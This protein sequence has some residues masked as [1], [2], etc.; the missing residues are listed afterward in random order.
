MAILLKSMNLSIDNSIYSAGDQR[1]ISL[2]ALR[3]CVALYVFL[4][5]AQMVNN[6]GFG[7]LMYFGQEAVI[8]FFIL[9]GFVISYSTGRRS[10]GVS[11]YVF[12]R[13]RRIYPI[14]FVA[15]FLAYLSA[16]LNF[17]GLVRVDFLALF[18][19]L[20]MLQDVKSLKDG[21]WFDTYYG[22]S[23]LWSLSYEWWFYMMYVP[24][25]MLGWIF[26][27]F[28]LYAVLLISVIGFLLFRWS[29]QAPFLYSSYF[30][31]WWMGV[32]MAREF[33]ESREV[34]FRVQS[35]AIAGLTIISF[36]WV[37]VVVRDI[38]SG[39]KFSFGV[40]DFLHARHFL[41]ALF[42]SI[43]SVAF[44]RMN[45]SLPVGLLSVLAHLSKISYFI[46]VAHWPILSIS[47]WVFSGR[48]VVSVGFAL[49][50]VLGLGWLVEVVL[51]SKLQKVFNY[52]VIVK[53]FGTK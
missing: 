39:A 23:P 27:S 51:Q 21:V 15:L 49:I 16:S 29:P 34:S 35:K 44:F 25:A 9:S 11:E 4:H 38:D 24:V 40:G 3:G 13:F 52:G 26:V 14:F 33:I 36:L 45:F 50:I 20:V 18:G 30:I 43:I 6:S 47:D 42:F 8:I 37:Y 7:R 12:L 5:H 28:Q 32:S 19:N 53:L 22:N 46:Y 17:G 41:G 31:I 48:S 2:E 1:I 10:V